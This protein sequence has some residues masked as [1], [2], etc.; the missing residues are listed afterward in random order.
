MKQIIVLISMIL[1]G[2]TI[3]GFVMDFSNSA[4]TISNAT[5]DKVQ[6]LTT[7]GAF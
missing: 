5:S 4:G 7:S 2:I 1:L 3:G 6:R